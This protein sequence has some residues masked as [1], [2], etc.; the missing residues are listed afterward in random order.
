MLILLCMETSEFRLAFDLQPLTLDHSI[1]L[2]LLYTGWAGGFEAHRNRTGHHS[3]FH[4]LSSIHE[5]SWTDGKVLVEYVQQPTDVF[6]ENEVGKRS[7]S[8]EPPWPRTSMTQNL[9]DPN[10]EGLLPVCSAVQWLLQL[11]PDAAEV[12]SRIWC[13]FFHI[14]LLFSERTSCNWRLMR[15]FL[16]Q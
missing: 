3:A 2:S 7:E 8:T 12:K 11:R 15:R 10:P 13:F 9:R 1:M 4:F 14:S 6:S 5:Y 16:R